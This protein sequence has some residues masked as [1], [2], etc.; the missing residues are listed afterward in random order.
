MRVADVSLAQL[1][2]MDEGPVALVLAAAEAGF[3]SVGLPLR[4]GALKPL[5]TEIIDQPVKREIIAACHDTGVRIFDTEA[6]VLGHLP[7]DL[8]QVLETAAAL[9]ATRISCLG[10]EAR[11]GPGNL[12]DPA[13]A[14][15]DLCRE[16]A[17]FDLTIAVEFM[18]FRSINSLGAAERIVEA[19]GSANAGIVLDALHIQRTGAT[20]EQIARL[21]Q[22][23]VSHLQLC[24]ARLIAPDDLAQEARGDRL[25]PGEGVI[26]LRAIIDALP[27]GTPVSLEMPCAE[28][29]ALP[30]VERAR[31]GAASIGW[32]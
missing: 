2:L 4:S 6:L 23:I 3:G 20:P 19:S 9:G 17:Q 29:A 30:V 12:R 32:L 28:L 26:S 1:G 5:Q 14:L 10:H 22:G 25:L 21:R 8:P 7:D 16:A 13:A 15:A 27:T 18:G 11:H 24:D 31:I